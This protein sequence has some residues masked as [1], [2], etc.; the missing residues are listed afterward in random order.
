MKI[1]MGIGI[2]WWPGVVVTRFIWSTKLLY[3][4]LG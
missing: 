1:A 4:G 3:N 2:R